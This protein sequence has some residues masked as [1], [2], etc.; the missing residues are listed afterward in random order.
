[1]DK[2]YLAALASAFTYLPAVIMWELIARFG[3][4]REVFFADFAALKA[5]GILP[6]DLL[7][8]Y[9]SRYRPTL[10][11]DLAE[12]CQKHA[13]T[14]ID[15]R[16]R[17]YPAPLRHIFNPPPVLYMKGHW[18]SAEVFLAMV[19]SRRASGYG[20]TVAKKLAG[21]LAAKNIVIVSGG[22]YGI[23]AASH[24]GVL[25]R[26]GSTVAVLGGGFENLYPLSNLNLF[27][28]IQEKGA[29]VTEYPP[30]IQPLS[31]HFPLRNRIIV[32][33]SRSVLVVEAAKKSGAIITAHIALEEG[34]DVFAVPGDITM[35]N[36]VGTNSLIQEG[37][38]LISCPEDVL[39]EFNLLPPEKPKKAK[40]QIFSLF[41]LLPENQVNDAEKVMAVIGSHRSVTIDEIVVHS[42]LPVQKVAG[43]LLSLQIKNL[44]VQEAG[45]HYRCN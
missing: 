13:V 36:S 45:N 7:K 29:L 30:D 23:D 10:P 17:L 6:P 41:N 44:I 33:L 26:S 20:L 16:E 8:R 14:L 5:I 39:A 2:Y 35:G 1:M 3:S 24:K 32:G 4:A 25:E 11:D 42:G 31:H 38:K 15:F 22:A 9:M 37:A 43:L 34:R 21:A 12:Y 18:P 19:G 28:A 27:A 40:A